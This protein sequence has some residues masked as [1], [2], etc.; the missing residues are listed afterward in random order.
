MQNDEH[1][2]SHTADELAAMWQRGEGQTNYAY[3][4]ALTDDE[5]EAS[6]TRRRAKWIGAR[7]RSAS[8]NRSS[9]SPLTST[10]T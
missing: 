9:P 5:L 6:I 3:L 4:D 2:V 8:P 10:E 7:S 1:I